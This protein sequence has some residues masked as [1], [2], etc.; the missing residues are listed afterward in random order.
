MITKFNDYIKLLE[1]QSEV[2]ESIASET[3][4]LTHAVASRAIEDSGLNVNTDISV[5][6]TLVKKAEE[7]FKTDVIFRKK[8]VSN[9][10]DGNAGRDYLYNQMKKWIGK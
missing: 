8:V 5:L 7:L 9:A 4:I 6:K 1:A 3:T 2:S 10:K